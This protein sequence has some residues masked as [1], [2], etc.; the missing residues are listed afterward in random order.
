[1]QIQSQKSHKKEEEEGIQLKS[2]VSI[3]GATLM[4]LESLYVAGERHPLRDALPLNGIEGLVKAASSESSRGS[5]IPSR[6]GAP[7]LR[8]AG[9]RESAWD[10]RFTADKA[11]RGISATSASTAAR[12]F[13]QL[14]R[15]ATT[16]GDALRG[17]SQI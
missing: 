9:R 11:D 8:S 10:S 3:N 4:N 6:T 5:P 7:L 13:P 17:R 16:S 15:N 1:M 14:R 12:I 2:H